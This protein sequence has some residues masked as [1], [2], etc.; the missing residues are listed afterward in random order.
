M[1]HMTALKGNYDVIIVGA[2]IQGLCA[3]HTFLSIDS[4]LSLLIVDDKSSVG[5]TWAKEQVYPGLRVN[6]LQ[7]YFEFSDFPLLDADVGV[8]PR[9]LISGEATAAYLHK[10]AEHFELLPRLRFNTNVMEATSNGGTTKAWTLKLAQVG[11]EGAKTDS[12][13]TCFKLLVTTGQTSRPFYPSY[14]GMQSFR[15]KSLHTVDL[16]STGTEILQDPSVSHIT[17]VG[18]GKSA[19]DAVYR[20]ATNGRRVTWIVRKTGRGGLWLAKSY[21]QIGPF[22]PWLEGL[23]MT[24][25]LSWFGA[26]PW[27]INDGFGGL[28]YLLHNTV[29]GR[30]ITRNYFA[31]MSKSTIEQSGILKRESTK[32]LVPKESLMWYGGQ[33]SILNYDTDFYDTIQDAGVKILHGDVLRLDYDAVIFENGER[34]MTDALVYATG[35]EFGPSFPLLPTTKRIGWGVP[36]APSPEESRTFKSLDE[37]ADTELFARFPELK[38]SPSYPERE[39]GATPWRLW[40][41]IAPPSQVVN[42]PRNLAF[43]TNVETYQNFLKS[44]LASLWTYAY[45]NNELDAQPGN[46]ADVLYE[47]SLWSR[48]GKW[49]CPMGSQGKTGDTLHDNMPYYDTLLRDLGLKSWRKGWGLLGEVFGGAY[50]LKDYK[51]IVGEWIASRKRSFSQTKKDE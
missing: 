13:V 9:G 41:F 44:E 37:R 17:I 18:G 45:L 49:R 16:A 38:Q 26:A 4:S 32:Q 20:F 14:P 1:S 34:I 22:S 50:E 29:V 51:G 40:R 30:F 7:G 47:A 48:F 42:G 28:R 19:H 10:Y 5:G 31:N 43:L 11:K 46:E 15:K 24:R 23:L 39:P 27:S 33:A 2:G 6:N 21:P 3:A 35:Y 36:V 12:T 8:K 25:P